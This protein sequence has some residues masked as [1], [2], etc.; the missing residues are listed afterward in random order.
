MSN[1]SL[2]ITTMIGCPV[3]CT[4][5]PQDSLRDAYGDDVKYMSLEAFK[6]VI[7]KV[8]TDTRLDFS[9]QAEPWVNPDCTNMVEYALQKGFRLAIFTTLYNWDENTVHRMGELMLQYAS[10]INIFKIH[11]PDEAGNMRGWKPS[12]EWE[13]AYIGMR[14]IVQSAGIHYEAMTM[15]DQGVHPAI[16]HLPGVGVSHGWT[17]AAHDRAGTLD[18]AQVKDQ[19][20][21]FA[22]KHEQPVRCG[23]TPYYDQGVLLPN[24]EVLL[25]CM[26]YEKKHV[27]G[28]LLEHDYAALATNPAMIKLQELNALPVWTA[29]SLCKSCTDAVPDRRYLNA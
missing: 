16:Q 25:C 26:D 24:G 28:N 11:F 21:K 17:I 23:K 14:T 1:S 6:I 10:Q 5:C 7:D 2:E 15:S 20:I 18:V 13:Y 19:P 27:M 22:P 4:Y 8:P 29:E 9:G 3:M 12:A